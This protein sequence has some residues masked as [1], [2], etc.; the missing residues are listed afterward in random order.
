MTKGLAVQNLQLSF[1]VKEPRD[2]IL[3]MS[4]SLSHI[5]DIYLYILNIYIYIIYILCSTDTGR[6]TQTRGNDNRKT[7]ICNLGGY[8]QIFKIPYL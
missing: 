2:M 5:M 6:Q 1:H 3:G 8:V 7:S 4:A